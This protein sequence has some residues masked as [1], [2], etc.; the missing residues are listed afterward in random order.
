M[1]ILA[2]VTSLY[3]WSGRH[4]YLSASHFPHPQNTNDHSFL[5]PNFQ[6]RTV[7]LDLA[8]PPTS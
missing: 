3:V 6:G 2:P 7:A 1:W 4:V 8:S 5:Q